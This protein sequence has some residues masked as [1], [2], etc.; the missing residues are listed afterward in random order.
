MK[1]KELKE[2]ELRILVALFYNAERQQLLEWRIRRVKQA[3]RDA[4]V[5]SGRSM[6]S[7]LGQRGKKY[8]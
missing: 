5:L 4:Q 7:H 3:L 6:W 8:V 1:E 2:K